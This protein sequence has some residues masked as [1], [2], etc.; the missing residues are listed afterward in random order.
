M[1]DS[2]ILV[3]SLTFTMLIAV[4]GAKGNARFQYISIH[5][6]WQLSLLGHQCYQCNPC[7]DDSGSY[8]V[9]DCNSAQEKCKLEV[10]REYQN[11]FQRQWLKASKPGILGA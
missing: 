6:R 9:I 11:I 5:I 1:T 4:V 7:S 3:L 2:R 10:S 8:N